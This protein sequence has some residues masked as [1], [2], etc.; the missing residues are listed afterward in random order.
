MDPVTP[1]L[2]ATEEG[3]VGDMWH[4]K[5]EPVQFSG[6]PE[7]T[8]LPCETSHLRCCHLILKLPEDN[9]INYANG[10]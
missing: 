4:I 7:V 3:R 2:V 1:T 6:P 10:E 9:L 8:T 5:S